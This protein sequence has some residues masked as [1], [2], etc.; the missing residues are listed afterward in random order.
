MNIDEYLD[1]DKDNSPYVA[2]YI[3]ILDRAVRD[4]YDEESRIR[5]CAIAWFASEQGPEHVFSFLSC[6]EFLNIINP[7]A[8]K[9][10]I[11]L[12]YR[13]VQ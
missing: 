1:E 4:L 5:D 13:Y 8:L 11:F 10:K 6:C 2:L 7:Q 12:G 3:A 9:D